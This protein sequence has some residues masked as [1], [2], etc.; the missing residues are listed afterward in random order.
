L[1]LFSII[2]DNLL[3]TLRRQRP[4][5][6]SLLR[7]WAGMSFALCTCT[8]AAQTETGG[9]V[10]SNTVW[11]AA[12]S[13]YIVNSDI[14]IQNGASLTIEPGTT[15][16]MGAGVNF[17]VTNGSLQAKGSALQPIII[18][19]TND[20]QN[21]SPA[22]GDWGQ[23]VFQDNS[24]DTKNLV[25]WAQIRYG[26][27]LRIESASPTLNYVAIQKQAG[28]AISA[29]LMSSPKGVGLSATGNTLNGISLPNGEITDSVQW[30]L[31]GIPYVI[32]Q[33]E[34]S[35]GKA[36]VITGISPATI[37]QGLSIDAV[38]TGFRLAGA[39]GI[40]FDAP[41]VTA[42]LG[43][44]VTDTAI[45][46][47]I[48]AATTQPIGS[49]PF[50]V[51]TA[52]G[53]VHFTSGI[54]V[55]AT[56]PT[57][58]ITSIAPEM[59]RRGES[60][61]LQIIGTSLAGA[62]IDTPTGSGLTVSSV[63]TSESQMSFNLAASSS[64]TVGVQALTIS[65]PDVANSAAT[66]I[67]V[68]P[69]LPQVYTTPST[70]VVPPNGTPAT[71]SLMLSNADNLPHTINL[72]TADSS[73][74]TVSPASVILQAGV[75]QTAITVSGLKLGTTLLNM[76]SPTLESHSVQ[77][78]VTNA[79]SG[80]AVGP[81]LSAVVGVKRTIDTST[82]PV[83]M[84]SGSVVTRPVGVERV[85]D[86][87]LLPVGATLGP[88]T[89]SPVGV[90]RPINPSLLPGGATLGPVLSPVVGVEHK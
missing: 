15:V 23:I 74:A 20:V 25:E 24:D 48:T 81:L 83:G 77:I 62:K 1:Y 6:R 86:P 43:S 8:A 30:L 12:Q 27:G 66:Y 63:T 10:T 51:Q 45:P 49:M 72:S 56:K 41:G 21:G 89:S 58:G 33:G 84:S 40:D 64:A 13:P 54:S 52:A 29:D 65:N 73:I 39:E 38:I 70:W 59:L 47:H 67:T 57:I 36:P 85:V 69:A 71:F 46:V 44:G 78:Y 19:S 22:P 50:D 42:A 2:L 37:Q 9:A 35:V 5:K 26:S 34:V 68:N 87:S 14:Q 18:T 53:R 76:T 60:K 61:S 88:V 3:E 17:I 16:Y 79:L 55:I 28:P 32:P 31:K 75:T 90:T 11:H 80:A 7:L 82:L 4:G